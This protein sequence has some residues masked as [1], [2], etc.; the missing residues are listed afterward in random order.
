MMERK[1]PALSETQ[2]AEHFLQGHA[3]VARRVHAMSAAGTGLLEILQNDHRAVMERLNAI[4]STKT[5]DLAAVR[6]DF[7]EMKSLLEAHSLAEERV[8]YARLKQDDDAVNVILE[9]VADHEM[10]GRALENMSS[11]ALNAKQWLTLAN[12]LREQLQE[13]IET[14]EGQIFE[15]ARSRF[16]EDELTELGGQM[17]YEKTRI[18]AIVA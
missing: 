14:E 5:D 9:A 8:L 6:A 2:L 7:L 4:C 3:V 16:K 1:A 15:A 11:L 12:S 18:F 13:H 17:Q 10:V